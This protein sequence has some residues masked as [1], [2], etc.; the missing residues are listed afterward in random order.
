MIAA[1][2]VQPDG[3][4]ADV[5]DVELWDEARDARTYDGP[6]SVVVFGDPVATPERC[7]VL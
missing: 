3:C 2:Y 5:P 1:L 7:I 4:Y 6:W